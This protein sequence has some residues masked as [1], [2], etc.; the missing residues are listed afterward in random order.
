MNV[1]DCMSPSNLNSANFSCYLILIWFVRT[2][3]YYQSEINI[4]LMGSSNQFEKI[5]ISTLHGFNHL[6]FKYESL[7]CHNVIKSLVEEEFYWKLNPTRCYQVKF[8][9]VKK[10]FVSR[11][12]TVLLLLHVICDSYQALLSSATAKSS[13]LRMGICSLSVSRF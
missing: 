4:L 10:N 6:R 8:A 1:L 3:I 2:S 5:R 9:F 7:K 13:P 12:F 11:L